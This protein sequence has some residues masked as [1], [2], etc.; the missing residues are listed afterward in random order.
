MKNIYKSWKTSLVGILLFIAAGG[1]LFYINPVDYIIL[2]ILLTSGIA[3]MFFPDDFITQ[4][5]SFL[6]K[7][8]NDV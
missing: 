1:Y 4:L 8:S 5:K 7:K 3:L 2:G 6:T